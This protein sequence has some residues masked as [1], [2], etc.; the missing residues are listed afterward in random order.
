MTFAKRALIIFLVAVLAV[1]AGLAV[2]TQDVAGAFHYP[3][4]FG[5]GLTDIGTVRIY[6]PWAFADWYLRYEASH[7]GSSTTQVCGA[8]WRPS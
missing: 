1:M 5:P 6:P 4:A 8:S 3:G 7:P 2:A